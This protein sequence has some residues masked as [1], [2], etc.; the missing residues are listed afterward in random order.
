MKKLGFTIIELLVVIGIML[1][2]ASILTGIVYSVLVGSNKSKISIDV[3]QGGNFAL[4]AMT[5]IINSSDK[6]TKVG[7]VSVVNCVSLPN[8]SSIEFRR[9]DS[10]YTTLS[11]SGGGAITSVSV[12]SIVSPTPTPFQNINLTN[13]LQVLIDGTQ[14]RTFICKQPDEFSNPRIEIEF[15]LK[16]AVGGLLERKASAKFKT[17]ISMRNYD[18]N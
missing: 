8:G 15:T 3:S 12:G 9:T 4:S 14:T 5:D 2:V 1:A 17:G 16:E 13:T 10:T 18:P 7:G 11:F 6:V